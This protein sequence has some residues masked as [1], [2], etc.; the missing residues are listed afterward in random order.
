MKKVILKRTADIFE[1]SAIASAAVGIFQGK[2]I[3]V[4]IAIVSVLLSYI[5]TYLEAKND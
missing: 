3:G 1:K 4:W 2:D 5:F